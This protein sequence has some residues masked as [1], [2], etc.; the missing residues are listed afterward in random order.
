MRV[1]L[2]TT[3]VPFVRGGADL[4][5]EWLQTMLVRAGHEVEVFRFPFVSN[6]PDMLEQMLALD[7][8]AVVAAVWE[9]TTVTRFAASTSACR[10]R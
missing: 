10:C 2:A 7:A 3:F 1:V 4:I 9:P 5:V 6:P 8:A